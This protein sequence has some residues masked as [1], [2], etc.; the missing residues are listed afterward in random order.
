MKTRISV[1]LFLAL[2]LIVPLTLFAR[3]ITPVVSTEWVEKNLDNAKLRI[4]DIR[5]VEEYKE[6]H[7]PGAV[8]AFYGTWAIK[9]GDL[10]N[11]VPALDDLADTIT[12]AGISR[13]SLVVVVGKADNA[14]ELTNI[15]RVA[16]TLAYAGL[17]NVSIL[18][19]GYNKWMA[20][21]KQVSQEATKPTSSEYKPVWN[22]AI[23]VNKDYVLQRMKKAALVDVRLPDYF[24]G[25]SKFDFVAKPGHIPGAVCLPSAWIF[26]KDGTFKG[27]EDLEAMAA[28]VIGKDKSKEII[29]YCDTGKVCTAW[30]YILTEVLGYKN[31]KTYDGS[32][33]EWA[34]DPK[35]PFV[36]Y[37]WK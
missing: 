26:T 4:I 28:G 27:K 3:D 9:R 1:H 25:V 10:Q 21:K 20:E 33:E 34:K 14:G 35:A 2:L 32:T 22:K 19:G 13:E 5:K 37:T 29:V 31:V 6:G 18:D 36:K 8:S 11:E 15:S 7:I 24:F 30:W 23:V 17:S 12:S 16:W